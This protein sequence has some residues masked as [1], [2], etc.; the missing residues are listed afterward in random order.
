MIGC[1][2]CCV[3]LNVGIRLSGYGEKR[4]AIELHSQIACRK[5]INID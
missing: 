2:F 3:L 4:K 1:V 5:M